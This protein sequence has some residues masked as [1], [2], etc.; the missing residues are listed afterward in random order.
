MSTMSLVAKSC[1]SWGNPPFCQKINR[2][3]PIFTSRDIDSFFFLFF[4]NLASLLGILGAMMD[5]IAIILNCWGPYCHAGLVKT[6]GGVNYTNGDYITAWEDMIFLKCVPGIAF[7]LTFG[8]FWYAWMA[9]KLAG[10]ENRTDVTALPYGINTPAGFLAAFSVMLPL[11]FKYMGD[12]TLTPP[13]YVEKAWKGA[14]TA[15]FIGG[16]FE[17]IGAWIGP[18]MPYFFAR[19]AIWTP[20][21]CVG[22]VW[23]GF[24]PFIA[25]MKEPIIGAIPLAITFIGFFSN[26][27]LGTG[28]F[29]LPKTSAFQF[30]F[31][32]FFGCLFMWTGCG[33]FDP[34]PSVMWATVESRAARYAGKNQMGAFVTLEGFVDAATIVSIVFPVAIQSFVETM[35]NVE[36]AAVKGDKY[37]MKEAMMVDGLGTCFG[38][39][40]G[41]P[42]PT[43]VYIGH[44]RHK[45]R[46][47]TGGYCMLNAVVYLILCLS[48]LLPVIYSLVDPV[49]VGCS[50]I[51]VGL[52]IMQDTFEQSVTRHVPAIAIGLMFVIADPW[53]FDLRDVT[54]AY[55]TRTGSRALGLKNMWPGG[56]ILCSLFVTQIL[57]DI[58]D[59]K[60]MRG[61]IFAFISMLFSL[62]GL[63]HGNNVIRPDGTTMTAGVD[64]GE[65]ELTIAIKDAANLNEGWRFC[66]FYAIIGAYLF[67]HGVVQK[68]KPDWIQP[69]VPGNGWPN[70]ADDPVLNGGEAMAGSKA[71]V[72]SKSS[73]VAEA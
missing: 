55:C 63:M 37:N 42:L 13:M 22:F 50:L 61:S 12:S 64:A 58:I 68:L 52:F 48:G 53:N 2:K 9:F 69:P 14:C 20:I 3:Y 54:T 8:N 31:I 26:G 66:I 57:C 29:G 21:A 44:T 28:F 6:V 7:A 43:T 5:I 71:A 15:T 39:L 33:K 1:C 19:A 51:A 10:Y 24:V 32:V 38:A 17:V 35:E 60:F 25:V 73:T 36:L 62:F 47:A 56:G 34:A 11:G 30:V 16:L 41:A 4:D 72:D 40:F 49:S 59:S 46:Q 23:L 65:G 27:G 45:L 67:G 70:D 18:A